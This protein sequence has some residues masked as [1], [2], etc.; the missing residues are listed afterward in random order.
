MATAWNRAKG[1]GLSADSARI[2]QKKSPIFGQSGNET[3]HLALRWVPLFFCLRG[4][5][6]YISF[7]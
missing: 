2:D 4:W 6:D 7:H 1:F 3:G 5:S